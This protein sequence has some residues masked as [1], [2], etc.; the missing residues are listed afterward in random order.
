MK[1][2]V[3]GYAICKNE[4]T[5]V[6][7][8]MDS[9]S[10]ADGVYVLDTGSTD[11]TV[12]KLRARGAHVTAE[13][14]QPWRFDVARNRSL[15]LV[16]E[17]G[18]ILVCTDLDEAFEKGWRMALEKQWAED[19]D[20]A[21]Y[22]YTWNFQED[23]SEGVVFWIEKIHRR[24][25]F[26]WVHPVHE[27]LTYTGEGEPKKAELLGVQL[28]HHAD[29]TKPRAQYLPLLELS[30]KECPEDDRNMHY[31][32]REYMYRGMWDPCI[33]TL[34]RHLKLESATWP[35]E[36][37][38]SMRYIARA[39]ENKGEDAESERWLYRA[40]GEAPHLREPYMDLACFYYRKK[41]WFGVIHM[42]ES[43]LKIRERSMSYINEP[44]SW[45]SAPY[46]LAAIAYYW[47]GLPEKALEAV[48]QALAMAPEDERLKANRD[49]ILEKL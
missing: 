10:E 21:R 42:A 37:A 48:D 41:N 40:I 47:A 5:F 22:R 45:G 34:K 8:W 19:T 36:R 9:M 3:Y 43:A 1:Y 31:L 7:A 25:G 28:N 35:D 44:M 38:A 6:D 49:W 16:P 29:P 2:K 11:R 18:D 32:G 17:D 27:V 15:A 23:G 14:I 46:D 33:E 13:L 30:V 24:H 12:E 39:Y 26:K 20:Q 4:E